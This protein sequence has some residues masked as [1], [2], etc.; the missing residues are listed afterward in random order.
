MG[1]T[2]R[3][4]PYKTPEDFDLLKCSNNTI[5]SI[6][7]NKNWEKNFDLPVVQ[8]E[9]YYQDFYKERVQVP[10]RCNM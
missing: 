7:K 5:K 3:N 9:K 1:K 8:I 10:D 6:G 4:H 2:K